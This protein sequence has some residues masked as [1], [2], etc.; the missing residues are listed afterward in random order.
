MDGM[1]TRRLTVD[2]PDDTYAKLEELSR[3]LDSPL[4]ETV[5]WC[6]EWFH[7]YGASMIDKGLEIDES[8]PNIVTGL[9][10]DEE[11]DG[12]V[13]YDPRESRRIGASV[14]SQ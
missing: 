4:A 10:A 6:V 11:E 5:Y 7:G 13:E 2:I 14:P 1:K 8:S 3:R 9:T 12:E